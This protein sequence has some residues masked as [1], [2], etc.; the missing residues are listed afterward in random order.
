ME[1]PKDKG[2]RSTL[3][4]MTVLRQLGYAMYVPFGENTRV[5]L[6]IDDGRRLARIQCKTGRLRQGA[7]RFSACSVSAHHRRPATY[8]DYLG[9][10]DFFA[11][12]CPETSGVY[13]IPIDEAPLRTAGS[14]RIDPPRNNQRKY[15][16]FAA[17]Y[18]IGRV[19]LERRG[20]EAETD[21]DR[22]R[23]RPAAGSSTT[24]V[25]PSPGAERTPRRPPIRSTSP[26]EM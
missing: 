13:L 10:I 7:V 11:V 24:K 22:R 6:V 5:D 8:R 25:A 9:Q 19:Q 2:D 18:E 23:A 21:R 26:R 20:S 17:D 4:I 1:R 12:Y 14:L 15:I 3:A 16:R